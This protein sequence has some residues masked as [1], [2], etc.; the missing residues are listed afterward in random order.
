MKI[1]IVGG[2][3]LIGAN[4]SEKLRLLGHEVVVAS[5][6]QGINAL[7]GEGL[8]AAMENAEVVVDLSNSASPEEDTAISFFRIAGKNLAE[9]EKAAGVKHHLILSIV[10]V[11]RALYIGYLR[12]KKEQ[13]DIIK[14]SGIPY[15]IIRATQFHEHITTLI[16]VQSD[17]EAVHISTVDYQPIAAEDVAALVTKLAL[18]APKNAT[19]E[20]AGPEL[21]PMDEFVSRYLSVK[22]GE[23][24]VKANDENKYMFFEIPKSLLVP[25]GDF[26]PGTIRFD[27]WMNS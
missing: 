22:G 10:G 8:A 2:T 4:V 5:P 24:P 25:Q 23:K 20:I 3:G 6:S 7:T 15:T 16:A 14:Q 27:D 21:A 26:Y 13:E 9:A 18:E 17:E 11:D 1:V 12:A 19:V